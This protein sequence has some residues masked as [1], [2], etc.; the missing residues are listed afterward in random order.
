MKLSDIEDPLYPLFEAFAILTRL[1]LSGDEFSDEDVEI[2]LFSKPWLL[3]SSVCPRVF[4][5]EKGSGGLV[6]ARLCGPLVLSSSQ[7]RLLPSFGLPFGILELAQ[8]W[9]HDAPWI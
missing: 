1:L 8:S 2:T 4:E 5:C 9:R 3:V 7:D 6:F